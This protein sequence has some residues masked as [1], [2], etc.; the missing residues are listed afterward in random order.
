VDPFR[1]QALVKTFAYM[2]PLLCN[3][4]NISSLG[5]CK[6][7]DSHSFGGGSSGGDTSTL[8]TKNRGTVHG[9]FGRV[10]G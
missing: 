2:V 10:A 3:Y 5:R 4:H 1:L 7:V 9:S 8:Y 6:M